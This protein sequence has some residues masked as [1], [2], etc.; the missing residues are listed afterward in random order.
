M[1]QRSKSRKVARPL[2]TK[3][4]VG[5]TRRSAYGS[6][7]LQAF[8]KG[9]QTELRRLARK[10]IATVVQTEGK[11]VHAIPKKVGAKFKVVA[12]KPARSVAR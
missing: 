11:V 4:A 3:A 5:S 6:Q 10:G 8:E 9:V 12:A 2:A 1:P 7:V